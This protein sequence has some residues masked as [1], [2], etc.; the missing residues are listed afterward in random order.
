[1]KTRLEHDSLGDIQ[2]PADAYYG[3]QTLRALVNF[4]DVSG[5]SIGEHPYYIKALAMV[6]WAAA[7][8]NI[9]LGTL[10]EEI[11]AAI[12][13]ACEEIMEG[14]LVDQFPVDLI[15][16]GAGTSTNMNIN[17]SMMTNTCMIYMDSGRTTSIFSLKH[18]SRNNIITN[19]TASTAK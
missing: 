16:G 7:H 4:K 8:A 19:T 9:S 10:D 17:V 5:L 14:A 18:C 13:K 12:K 1:M 15:Q 6:K 2:V 3:A 11:G